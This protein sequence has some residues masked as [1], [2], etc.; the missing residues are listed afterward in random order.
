GEEA[1]VDQACTPGS[2]PSCDDGVECTVGTCDELDDTCV[3][4]ED[5]ACNGGG[6]FIEANGQVVIEAEHFTDN[7]PRSA[8]EWSVVS[9]AGASGTAVVTVG[10]NSG[11]V[12]NSNYAV[13]SPELTYRVQFSNVGTYY[14]WLRGFGPTADDDSCHIGLDG[15]EVGSSDRIT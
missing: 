15:N 3:Y 5:P 12:I 7:T 14:V 4:T 13:T 2:A 10:P 11:Q 8:H 9:N 6:V 1:C